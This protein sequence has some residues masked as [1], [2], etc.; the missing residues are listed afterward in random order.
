MHNALILCTWPE[1][2]S[3]ST[4]LLVLLQN[5]AGHSRKYTPTLYFLLACWTLDENICLS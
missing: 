5:N 2:T 4:V 1:G 3:T